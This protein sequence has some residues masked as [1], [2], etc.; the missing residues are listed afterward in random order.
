MCNDLIGFDPWR[1]TVN[2]DQ[3]RRYR[4]LLLQRRD[5][6][7]ALEQ[8][9]E[10]ATK[11]VELDQSRVGR[12]SRIDALQRQA[13]SLET[14]RRRQ[15]HLRR[16]A[17]ALARMDEDDYGFCKICGEDIAPARLEVDPAA[18][19]CIKCATEAEK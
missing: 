4:E 13:I 1:Q 2:P 19:Q 6:L 10:D 18:A 3:I 15:D 7:L 14:S 5:E 9:G 8:M 16:I 11:A 17:A 12:L